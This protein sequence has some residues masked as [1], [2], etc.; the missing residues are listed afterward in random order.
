MTFSNKKYKDI[1]G[2]EVVLLKIIDINNTLYA[3]MMGNIIFNEV[4]VIFLLI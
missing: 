1:I 4:S 2:L 3:T